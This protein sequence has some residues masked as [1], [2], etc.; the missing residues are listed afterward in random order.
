MNDYRLDLIDLDQP[1]A[2]YKKFLSCWVF[3]NAD[4]T[5]LV[6]P[7]PRSSVDALTA[8]LKAL[9][10]NKVDYV[11]A[12]HIHLDH[13]G[14]AAEVLAAFDGARFFCH[15]KGV[16]HMLTPER[17]W[18]GSQ[19][20]IG[21]VAEMY[22][23]P[24]LLPFARVASRAELQKR[25]LGVID[26]PGHAVHHVC[27]LAD[28]VLFAG[29]A[30]ATRMLL[31][32]GEAYMR[33]ATPPRFFLDQ[34]LASLDTLSALDPEP[35]V[36][37]FAHYGKEAG[38]RVWCQ[39]AHAQLRLWVETARTCRQAGSADLENDIFEQLLKVD[40]DFARYFE[41]ESVLQERE[42]YYVGNNIKGILGY[43]ENL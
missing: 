31:P 30:I 34:N 9:G 3:R 25:G 42:R 32:A 4:L 5:I 41:L 43:L 26:T 13:A 35:R 20:T 6:D 8:S 15:E 38:L 24:S 2:G 12:T 23:K 16:P 27:F 29:E 19:K 11:L 18:A 28:E 21:E 33:P 17:L 10:V 36:T 39:R 1:K 40:A 37:A 7:G 14:G 22:G